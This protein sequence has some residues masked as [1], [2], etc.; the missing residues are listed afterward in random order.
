MNARQPTRW[1]NNAVT[2]IDNKAS[3]SNGT[4][5]VG[6]LTIDSKVVFGLNSVPT[7]RLMELTDSE[8]SGVGNAALVIL[9]TPQNRMIQG[10]GSSVITERGAESYI[11]RRS[12]A[13]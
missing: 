7:T 1:L 11:R 5:Q 3:K 13:T 12:F 10:F 2:P 8:A 4:S 6:R 9:L